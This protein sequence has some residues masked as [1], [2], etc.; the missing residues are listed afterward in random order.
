MAFQS[1]AFQG[2]AFQGAGGTAVNGTFTAGAV[3]LKTLTGSWPVNSVILATESGSTTVSAWIAGKFAV[4]AVV[5]ATVSVSTRKA[6]AVVKRRQES[7]TTAGASLKRTQVRSFAANA[8]VLPWFSVDAETISN[9]FR[10]PINA[11]VFGPINKTTTANADI[12]AVGDKR[13]LINVDA[14]IRGT[15]VRVTQYG[16]EVARTG[17]PVASASQ[18]GAQVAW[19]RDS[20][21]LVS[22]FGSEVAWTGDSNVL[23]SQFGAEVVWRTLDGR[24]KVFQYGF[25]RIRTGDP[26]ALASQFGLEIAKTVLGN[27]RVNQAG[28]E[29]AYEKPKGT[30]PVNAMFFRPWEY[31][32]PVTQTIDAALVWKITGPP[33]T[34]DAFIQWYMAVDAVRFQPDNPGTPFTLSAAISVRR[35][36]NFSLNAFTQGFLLN[37]VI[38]VSG[39]GERRGIFRIAAVKG[40]P[41]YPVD[42]WIVGTPGSFPVMAT[43]KANLSR[44]FTAS[45]WFIDFGWNKVRTF[46]A[47]A[48]IQPAVSSS[49]TGVIWTEA[50][51]ALDQ[52]TVVFEGE[53]ETHVRRGVVTE[54]LEF[55]GFPNNDGEPGG[56]L[57]IDNC[58]N[59]YGPFI[60]IDQYPV[61]VTLYEL[62]TW[63]D[64]SIGVHARYQ[65]HWSMATAPGSYEFLP[66]DWRYESY[67]YT[68]H[69]GQPFDPSLSGSGFVSFTRDDTIIDAYPAPALDAWI[70]GTVGV[71]FTVDAELV[72]A[73]IT[74]YRVMYAGAW[75]ND[76][77]NW[78]TFTVG[79]YIR[80]TRPGFFG[81]FSAV[82]DR[83]L[84]IDAIIHQP[85]FSLSAWI[86]SY[87][88]VDAVI[89]TT[90]TPFGTET[91]KGPSIDAVISRGTTPRAF[92]VDA[93]LFPASGWDLTFVDAVIWK[94]MTTEVTPGPQRFYLAAFIVQPSKSFTVG[95]Y[96]GHRFTAAAWIQPYF[97][98]GAHIR[99]TPYIIFP[100][101]GGPPTDIYGSSPAVGRSFRIKIEAGIPDP[102]PLGNDAEIER[103]IILIL[104]AEAE[105]EALYCAVTHYTPQGYPVAGGRNPSGGGHTGSLPP[106]I[107]QAGYPGGGDIDDC[108]VIADV[109][110]ALAS[111]QT[112]RP[113]VTQYRRWA[114]NPDRPGPTGGSLDH[115]MRAARQAW[116]GAGIRRYH[117][118][119]WDGFT[120]LLK[121]GWSASLSIR[122]LGLPSSWRY[123]FRDGMHRIGVVYQNGAYYYMDPNQ[124][125]GSA[126]RVVSGHELRTAAR[127]HSGGNIG[128]CMFR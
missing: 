88:T 8:F 11:I 73:V 22:Q 49:S 69:H 41:R 89:E 72:P 104:E 18:F 7:S 28:L 51:I 20:N 63:G 62:P 27:V 67:I 43:R 1:G 127:A 111:G 120:S 117:S 12:A 78:A 40:N 92:A 57:A 83:C 15:P 44:T 118:S 66:A 9:L 31:M 71:P 114:R 47:D 128:A 103:L 75:V 19:T 42:A 23:V 50:F 110:A 36:G 122:L 45:S 105:L 90:I 95:S 106:A 54:R 76:A 32:P 98:V 102:V 126:P 87:F 55:P 21:V 86:Q 64:R 125:N 52:R 35:Y 38:K 29:V 91:H 121:A 46:T 74:Q 6:D 115:S 48:S 2:N 94:T 79:A 3:V 113:T 14:I 59:L 119:N 99:G 10:V 101:D 30:F 60:T 65:N 124:H 70:V 53:G 25:E 112:F 37:A 82:A 16:A 24:T 26:V 80:S 4:G 17:I 85:N 107:A 33:W 68:N 108:W 100:E 13:G 61:V 97:T 123:G 116:P 84:L 5:K 39:Y 93:Y 34:A 58:N 56:K 81:V 77:I 96:I 109:W